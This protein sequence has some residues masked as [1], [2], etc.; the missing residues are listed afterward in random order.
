ME[1]QQDENYSPEL[2]A[3]FVI[4]SIMVLTKTGRVLY[5]CTVED[6]FLPKKSAM[7]FLLIDIYLV[8]RKLPMRAWITRSEK[9][10]EADFLC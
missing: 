10:S 8:L 4:Y 2:K 9:T 7:S 6:F 3:L 5:I 1:E